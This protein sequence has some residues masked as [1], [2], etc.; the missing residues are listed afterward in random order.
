MDTNDESGTG[1]TMVALAARGR[2][3]AFGVGVRRLDAALTL[4]RFNMAKP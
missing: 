1:V 3:K 2:A 4:Q